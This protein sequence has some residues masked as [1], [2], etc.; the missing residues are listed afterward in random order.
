M[1]VSKL[2]LITLQISS[3][4]LLDFSREAKS[5]W[6]FDYSHFTEF[7][8]NK[9]SFKLSKQILEIKNKK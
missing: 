3:I 9:I 6:F 7:A 8:A 2:S 1:I 4:F 5:F